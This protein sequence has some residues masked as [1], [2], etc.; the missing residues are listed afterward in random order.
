MERQMALEV[1]IQSYLKDW[2]TTQCELNRAQVQ[3]EDAVVDEISALLVKPVAEECG[4]HAEPHQCEPAPMREGGDETS[5]AA[6]VS[7]SAAAA[8]D[9]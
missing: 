2:V 7:R 4:D 3:G 8:L 9:A 5:E 6:S 1:N